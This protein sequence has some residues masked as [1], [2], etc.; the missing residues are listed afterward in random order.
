MYLETLDRLSIDVDNLAGLLVE[1]DKTRPEVVEKKFTD[2][3]LVAR[4]LHKVMEV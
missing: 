1:L 2:S 4:E 3:N